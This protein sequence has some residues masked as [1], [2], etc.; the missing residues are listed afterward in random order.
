MNRIPSDV[1][2]QLRE[3]VD[4]AQVIERLGIPS[5]RRGQQLAFR[6]PG[7]GSFWAV[8]SPFQ[9]LARCFH[10]RRNFNPIDLVMAE[11]DDTFLEAVRYLEGLLLR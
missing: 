4:L 3:D 1:L 2:R 10:C 7:C 11:R 9:N 6:C 5:K 8:T